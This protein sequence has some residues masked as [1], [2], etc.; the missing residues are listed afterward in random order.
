MATVKSVTRVVNHPK[1]FLT[2]DCKKQPIPM[3]SEIKVDESVAERLGNK[4]IAPKTGKKV[5]ADSA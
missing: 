4:L 3:G 5:S 2:V 1:L